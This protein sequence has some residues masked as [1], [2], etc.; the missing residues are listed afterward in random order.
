MRFIVRLS[1]FSSSKL[2]VYLPYLDLM[3]LTPSAFGATACPKKAE[4]AIT[5]IKYG[6]IWRYTDGISFKPGN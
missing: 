3:Q 4:S 6:A 1:Q 5:V 2:R